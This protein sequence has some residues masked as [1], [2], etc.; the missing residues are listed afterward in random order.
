MVIN[1]END[2]KVK[3]INEFKKNPLVLAFYAFSGDNYLLKFPHNRSYHGS[4]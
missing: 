4:P 3:V 2:K 1:K